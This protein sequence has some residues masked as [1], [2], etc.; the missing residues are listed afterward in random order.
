MLITHLEFAPVS[1]SACTCN[2]INF[3]VPVSCICSRPCACVCPGPARCHGIP[4]HIID[5][6]AGYC[7]TYVSVYTCIRPPAGFRIYQGILMWSSLCLWMPWPHEVQSHLQTQCGSSQEHTISLQL[8]AFCLTHY[9]LV[10]LCDTMNML[11]QIIP[12]WQ[13]TEASRS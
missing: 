8:Q 5:D 6:P 2:L 10:K 4:R 3:I 7:S 13:F 11:Y 9:G 1:A 12:I